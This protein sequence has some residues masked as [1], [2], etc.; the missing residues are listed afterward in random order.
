MNS[1]GTRLRRL[2]PV[3]VLALFAVAIFIEV[4]SVVQAIRQKSWSPMYTT[5]WVPVVVLASY[6]ASGT[7]GCRQLFRRRAEP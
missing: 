7:K 1:D 2:P 4:A 3:A 5:G 6:R